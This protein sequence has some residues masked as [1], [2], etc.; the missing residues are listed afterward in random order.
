MQY[1]EIIKINNM[2]KNEN[3]NEEL[4]KILNKKN[5]Q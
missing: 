5:L 2:L 3:N 4:I 1:K